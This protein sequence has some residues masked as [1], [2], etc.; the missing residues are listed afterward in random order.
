MEIKSPTDV[1]ITNGQVTKV[2]YVNR[3]RHCNQPQD[4]SA[5]VTNIPSTGFHL[6]LITILF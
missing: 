4:T 5:P 2:V 3:L 1:K 6:K